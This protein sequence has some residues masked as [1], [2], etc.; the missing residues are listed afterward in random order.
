[1]LVGLNLIAYMKKVMNS[2]P[3]NSY[4]FHGHRTTDRCAFMWSC[5]QGIFIS[6][7][8]RMCSLCLT[9][10]LISCGVDRE[11]GHNV[12]PVCTTYDW[13]QYDK[14]FPS[15]ISDI[16]YEL[17]HYPGDGWKYLHC[18]CTPN[19]YL[20]W[21][22]ASRTSNRSVSSRLCY[23]KKNEGLVASVALCVYK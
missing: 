21:H 13:F 17:H 4:H 22:T 10:L 9:P 15:T 20:L 7:V 23:M 3:A 19:L 8:R 11:R 18:V 12:D 5:G 6:I 2:Y 1:M 14:T 16:S